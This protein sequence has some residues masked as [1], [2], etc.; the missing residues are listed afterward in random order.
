MSTKPTALPRIQ[1][2][3]VGQD[4]YM[5]RIDV[6]DDGS[7][8]IDYGDYTSHKPTR[9]QVNDDKAKELLKALNE[10]GEPREHSPPDGATGFVA[11]LTIGDGR[12]VRHYRFWEG[13]LDA[14]PDL[15]RLVRALEVLG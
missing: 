14:D 10:L 15:R 7:F 11:N 5:L 13:A 6:G 4:D 8:V 3:V 9:G 1:Y 2:Q 12:S